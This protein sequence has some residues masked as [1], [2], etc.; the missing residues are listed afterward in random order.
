MNNSERKRS[1]FQVKN[2]EKYSFSKV[3][4]P[5]KGNFFKVRLKTAGFSAFF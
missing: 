3:Q 5:K 4:K 1:F 2:F